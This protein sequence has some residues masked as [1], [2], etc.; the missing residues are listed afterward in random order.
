M[1][2]DKMTPVNY[3][4]LPLPVLSPIPHSPLS[5]SSLYYH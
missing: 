1:A 5:Q 4:I 3:N 2:G